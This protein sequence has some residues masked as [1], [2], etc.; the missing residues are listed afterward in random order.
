M[1]KTGGN[2]RYTVLAMNLLERLLG[3]KITV[4]GVDNI[5]P[6]PV[7]FVANHFTRSETFVV[8]YIIYKYTKR[9]VRCLADSSLFH[10]VLGRFLKSVGALSTK[11][12][13]RDTAIIND[14][15]T[16]NYDWMIYPEGSMIKSKEILND[17]DTIDSPDGLTRVR[18]GSA[19]LAL[20]SELYRLDII[21]AKRK[22]KIEVLNYYQQQFGIGYNDDLK[23]I[24]TQIVPVNITYY[25]I[26]PGENIIKR[27]AGRFF[28]QIPEQISEEL[29]IEGNLLLSANINIRFEKP[30]DVSDYVRDIHNSIYQIPIINVQTKA[31]LVLK[32]LKY[33]LTSR[34]M[35]AVY[36]STQ[37][38]LDHLFSA[39]IHF[40]PQTTIKV[41]HIKN[42]IYLS[43]HNIRSL[44]KYRINDSLS[45]NNLCKMLAD[46]RY[47]HFESV[48]NLAKM[49]GII[50]ESA[51]KSSFII[52]KSRLEKKSNFNQIRLENTLQVIANE[53]FLLETASNVIK[54]NVLLSENRVRQSS[55]NYLVQ[56]DLE[57]FNEDYNSYYNPTI[58]KSKNI[59]TPFSLP[60][61]LLCQP[62]ESNND[63]GIVLVH[64]Y[65]AAPKEVEEMA[66]YFNGL[67]YK[68]YAVRLK[69]HGTT[70]INIE[71]VSWQDWY[72]SL[73]RGYAILKLLCS[74]VFIVGFSTGGSLALMSAFK[75]TDKLPAIV[76]INPALKLQDIRAKM[77]FGVQMWN[78]LLGKF[79]ISKGQLKYVDG[80]PENPDI[81]YSRNYLHGV[82]HLELLMHNCEHNLAK[83]HCPV[84]IIQ[85]NKDPVVDPS[86]A[87]TIIE[88]I[89]SNIKELIKLERTN[90]VI[91]RG[92]G[93]EEVFAK[94]AEFIKRL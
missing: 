67:G 11:D 71:D 65:L 56:K 47:D 9:P 69:G 78:E 48:V 57:I 81:N 54:K 77:V 59:G 3:S 33:R 72:D 68:I 70:P 50:Q 76:C 37:I 83:I 25:P 4:D 55:L 41:D 34:F 10:G 24:K 28:K 38:N 79:K 2:F 8:P 30:I 62:T 90:H 6:K 66:K 40:Y 29:E 23:N 73:N 74:K 93:K 63:V 12:K 15:V 85:G 26:R 84:L 13:N 80:Q 49:F 46:E 31:N 18:T 60:S 52:D 32:Y 58:S 19:V 17:G 51:D 22:D 27:I 92:N 53:F 44:K 75:K 16:G 86:C 91:I 45:E 20:K 39:I 5:P 14:L 42:L 35:D 88:K 43:A 1:F 87:M 64:G 7:L 94:V 82:E 61:P 89:S 21:D 36:C